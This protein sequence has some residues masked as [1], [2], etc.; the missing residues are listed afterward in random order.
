MYIAQKALNR[1]SSCWCFPSAGI[2]AVH[3]QVWPESWLSTLCTMELSFSRPAVRSV[4]SPGLGVLERGSVTDNPRFQGY[5]VTQGQHC[6]VWWHLS[7]SL[8][9]DPVSIGSWAREVQERTVLHLLGSGAVVGRAG[10]LLG[11]RGECWS[12]SWWADRPL[13][14]TLPFPQAPPHL[15]LLV[16]ARQIPSQHKLHAAVRV[17]LRGCPG[18]GVESSDS[19]WV[20]QLPPQHSPLSS[21]LQP[22]PT[23]LKEAASSQTTSI[24]PHHT[25]R[26]ARNRKVALACSQKGLWPLP[27]GGRESSARSGLLG[28]AGA[29]SPLGRTLDAHA[30]TS[31]FLVL[32]CPL[33]LQPSGAVEAPSVSDGDTPGEQVPMIVVIR[34]LAEEG[35]RLQHEGGQHHARQVH[36]RPQLT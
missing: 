2:T 30:F 29:P 3:H 20:P 18:I 27:H 11:H 16:E 33:P 31:L 22:P 36:A 25:S 24:P 35:A 8:R 28:A 14:E 6:C 4:I 17:F 13:L 5:H 7:H 34:E 26:W 32:P 21:T 10:R 9:K 19:G 23:C 15:G 12:H 1:K